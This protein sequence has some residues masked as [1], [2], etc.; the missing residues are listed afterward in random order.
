MLIFKELESAVKN[1]KRE[2]HTLKTAGGSETE[3]IALQKRLD[4]LNEVLGYIKSG[5]WASTKKAKERMIFTMKNGNEAAAE[6]YE[7]TL[8]SIKVSMSQYSTTIRNIIGVDTIQ[9]I[10]DGKVE[11]GLTQF[12]CRTG[13]LTLDTLMLHR[14]MTVFTRDYDI[15][16]DIKLSDCRVE[17]EFIHKYLDSS[18][19]RDVER[20]DKNKLAYI[21][22]LMSTDIGH[23]DERAALVKYLLNDLDIDEVIKGVEK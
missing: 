22:H 12:R 17:M 9:L 23:A 10:M 13:T 5:E 15:S 21:K 16:Q 11:E 8:S 20:C 1:T 2:I 6:K 19:Q 3:E 4:A 7:T 14:P 18:Y